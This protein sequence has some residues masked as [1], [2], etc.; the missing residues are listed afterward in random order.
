MAQKRYRI[1]QWFSSKPQFLNFLTFSYFKL[2]I[3]LEKS[4]EKNK[5]NSKTEPTYAGVRKVPLKKFTL[6]KKQG[7]KAICYM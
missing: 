5:N 3:N 7:L 2:K 6:W 1:T 4:K